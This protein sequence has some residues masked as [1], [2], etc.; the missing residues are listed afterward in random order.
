M[1][2]TLLLLAL[3]DEKGSVIPAAA[4][5]LNG[6]LIGAIL[7]ELALMGRLEQQAN[8][9]LLVDPHP[10]GDL[11]LDEV[12]GRMADADSPRAPSYW[13]GRLAG[14]MP[15][16]KDRL[17]EG[18]VSRGVLDQR[19][20]R[21]LW[22]F[23]SRSFPLADAA[24]EQQA[25]DRI[26]A[27]ILEDAQPDQRTSALIGLV[28]ACNLTNEIFAPHE[29]AH[30]NRR[31]SE[32]TS[33]EAAQS[34]VFGSGLEAALMATLLGSTILYTYHAMNQP[35]DFDD[36]WSF[37][38]FASDSGGSTTTMTWDTNWS[39]PSSSNDDS[40]WD[41]PGDSGGSDFGDG[42]DSSGSSD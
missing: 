36:G 18:L 28:R 38:T 21:I 14:T 9:M 17:L 40:S 25:R 7:M 35:A 8:G 11:L 12:L 19:E 30:A 33:E 42:G 10:T 6:A 2:D 39:D 13:V 41:S 20:R 22:V 1:P 31:V 37:T 4:M 23:P 32:L 16:L 34:T 27:V 24:A 5:A 26:R 15:R 29:R 3:H